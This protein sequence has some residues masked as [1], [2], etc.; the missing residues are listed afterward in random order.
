MVDFTGE[1]ALWLEVS[2]AISHQA[3][4]APTYGPLHSGGAYLVWAIVSDG[5]TPAGDIGGQNDFRTVST[6][7]RKTG[8]LWLRIRDVGGSSDNQGAFDVKIHRYA[9]PGQ[10]LAPLSEIGL[11]RSAL[12]ALTIRVQRFGRANGVK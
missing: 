9:D 1:D 7:Y 5:S 2:G 10:A 11:L 8:R 12:V 4:P 6:A 3:A